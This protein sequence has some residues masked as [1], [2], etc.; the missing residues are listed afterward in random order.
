MLKI[1][2]LEQIMNNENSDEDQDQSEHFHSSL[3]DKNDATPNNHEEF[4][5]NHRSKFSKR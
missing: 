4:F 2:M 3:V 1:Q 5:A